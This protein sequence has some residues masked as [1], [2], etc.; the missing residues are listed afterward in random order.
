MHRFWSHLVSPLLHEFAPRVLCEV[1]TASGENT[2][3]LLEFARDTG[4][5]LHAIDPEPGFPVDA[6]EREFGEAF[7]FHRCRSL[8]LLRRLTS[9]DVALLDGDR[10]W[11]TV[12]H[13]LEALSIRAQDSGRE[14]PLTLVHDV[15]WP[16]ARRDFYSDPTSVPADHRRPCT[17]GGMV[18]GRAELDPD[19]GLSLDRWHAIAEGGPRNGVMTAV[20]DFRVLR[21]DLRFV[22]VPGFHGLGLLFPESSIRRSPLLGALSEDLHRTLGRLGWFEV[23][24]DAR[25]RAEIDSLDQGR[26]S[27]GFLR[28]VRRKWKELLGREG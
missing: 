1:G 2:R 21:P 5:V 13:E 8:P 11:Y 28:R 18:P 24:E 7:R 16:Y 23:L 9:P 22:A 6:W 12:F 25:V 14:F 19:G 20:E 17:Q 4:A 26:R 27:R 10:N 3:N 15:A